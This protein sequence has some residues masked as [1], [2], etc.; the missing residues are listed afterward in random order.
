MTKAKR[1]KKAEWLTLPRRSSSRYLTAMRR[2]P[3]GESG[4]EMTRSPFRPTPGMPTV[5]S[6]TPHLQLIED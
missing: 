5:P 1:T 3:L 6:E 2:R 4:S